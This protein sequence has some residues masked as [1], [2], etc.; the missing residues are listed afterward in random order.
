MMSIGHDVHINPV[1]MDA[2]IKSKMEWHAHAFLTHLVCPACKPPVH[3][4]AGR[5]S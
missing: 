3:Q 4:R 1:N 2:E 5:H